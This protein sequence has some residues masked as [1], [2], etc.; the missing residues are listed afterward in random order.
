[1][2]TKKT[3]VVESPVL[4]YTLLFGFLAA[5]FSFAFYLPSASAGYQERDSLRP[6]AQEERLREET[7]EE[8]RVASLQEQ[9]EEEQTTK[10]DAHEATQERRQ[11]SPR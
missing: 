9:Q 4:F 11:L 3:R 2:K 10:T 5:F 1:M 6:I 8:R 7:K